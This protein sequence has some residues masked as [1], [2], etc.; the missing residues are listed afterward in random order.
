[1]PEYCITRKEIW[2]SYAYLTADDID[3]AINMA[4]DGEGDIEDSEYIDWIGNIYIRDLETDEGI[5]IE[6]APAY[7]DN[8]NNIFFKFKRQK[9]ID[10]VITI[11]KLPLS[12]PLSDPYNNISKALDK[13]E[14]IKNT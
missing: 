14:S 6:P 11:L 3:T 8:P 2:H 1:M 12:D 10:E 4:D 13:L 5:N 9:E 7:L